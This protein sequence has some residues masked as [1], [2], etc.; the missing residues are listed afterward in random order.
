MSFKHKKLSKPSPKVFKSR[1]YKQSQTLKKRVVAG[2]AEMQDQDNVWWFR[3]RSRSFR[4]LIVLRNPHRLVFGPG[5]K[6]LAQIEESISGTGLYHASIIHVLDSKV[7]RD[8][9]SNKQNLH[10]PC[11]TKNLMLVV[12]EHDVLYLKPIDKRANIASSHKKNETYATRFARLNSLKN[13]HLFKAG[14][15]IE[16]ANTDHHTAIKLGQINSPQDLNIIAMHE[17]ALPNS[18]SQS[19]LAECDA[20]EPLTTSAQHQDLTHLDFITIDD[21]DA[22]DFDDAVYARILS[23][24]D[25]QDKPMFE[26]CVAIADVSWYVEYHSNIDKEAFARGN[27]VYLPSF[28]L[29][30]LPEKIS[31]D[32]CSLKPDCLRPVLAVSMHIN[33]E[34]EIVHFDIMRGIIR[35]RARVTYCDAQAIIQEGFKQN[36]TDTCNLLDSKLKAWLQP[37][38]MVYKALHT[39]RCKRGSLDFDL[40]ET[41]ASFDKTGQ[42]KNF[43]RRSRYESHMLIEEAMIAANIVVGQTLFNAQKESLYRAHAPPPYDKI[44]TLKNQIQFLGFQVHLNKRDPRKML[45]DL[46]QDAKKRSMHRQISQLSVQAQ[47]RASYQVDNEGHFGLGLDCYTHFT[48]PIR[49]YADLWVHRGLIAC[50]NLDTKPYR[51]A[52]LTRQDLENIANHISMRERVAGQAEYRCIERLNSVWASQNIGAQLKGRVQSLIGFGAFISLED[53]PVQGFLHVRHLPVDYYRLL[54]NKMVLKGSSNNFVLK[55]F[56]IVCVEILSADFHTGLVDFS[57]I[58]KESLPSIRHQKNKKTRKKNKKKLKYIK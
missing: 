49:R 26:L 13:G 4:E 20:L 51:E 55:M 41:K 44:E 30:M 52:N 54:Q 22:Q 46:V 17:Y 2:V 9:S 25:Q 43:I 35:S 18:F 36:N 50:L 48:S 29:P 57:F 23:E 24:K 1:Q 14:D 8:P 47:A 32:L 19:V 33:S 39:S 6:I 45:L 15:L 11:N 28:C 5:S 16:I 37:L 7:L 34:G 56:D 53:Y 10:H 58:K 21:Q 40:S 27:S 31:N 12:Q 38:Y 3:A 42:L